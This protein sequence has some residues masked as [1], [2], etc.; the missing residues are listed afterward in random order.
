M[1]TL[2]VESVKDGAE[3]VTLRVVLEV[4]EPEVP[5]M[6]ALY[7]PRAAVLLAVNVSRLELAEVEMGFGENDAVT[8]LG[9]PVTVRLTLPVNPY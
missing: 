5:V 1:D 4:V 6:V 2:L 8:P 3:T 7:C 9:R